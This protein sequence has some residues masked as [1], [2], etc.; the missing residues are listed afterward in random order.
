[1]SAHEIR[2]AYWAVRHHWV[3]LY[4]REK[5]RKLRGIPE[6]DP[7]PGIADTIHRLYCAADGCVHPAHARDGS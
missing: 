6:P 2:R 3:R 5:W 1:V 7:L 4:L